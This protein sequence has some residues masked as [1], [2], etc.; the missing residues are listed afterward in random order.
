M[1]A[2]FIEDT[3]VFLELD[4]SISKARLGYIDYA[5]EVLREIQQSI[6]LGYALTPS[7]ERYLKLN[8]CNFLDRYDEGEDV[9]KAFARSFYLLKGRGQSNPNVFK[10]YDITL[11]IHKKI[12]DDQLTLENAFNCYKNSELAKRLKMGTSYENVKRIYYEHYKKVRKLS[13]QSIDS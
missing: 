13:D 3:E 6:D 5:V 2:Y 8:I 12:Q 4:D 7:Q 10:E 11:F 1:M 9:T